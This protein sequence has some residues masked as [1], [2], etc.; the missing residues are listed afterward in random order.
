MVELDGGEGEGGGQILRTALTLS[1][2]TG[3]PFRID[4]IRAN[5]DHPGLRPQHLACVEAL[6]ALTG[7]QAQGAEVGSRTLRFEPSEG[8]EIRPFEYD[9]GTAGSTG[10]LLQ[11]LFPIVAIQGAK[12]GLT[13][14]TTLTLRG[15]TYNLAAPSWPFLDRV[16]R[17]H[18]ARV[19]LNCVLR[20]PRAGYYPRGGGLLEADI[21][22]GRPRPVTLTQRGRPQR[23]LIDA[24]VSRLPESIGRRLIQRVQT[25]LTDHPQL[26]EAEIVDRLLQSPSDG[27]GC[28]VGITVEFEDPT[29][30]D[31]DPAGESPGVAASGQTIPP[32]S[33]SPPLVAGFVGLGRPGKSSEAV[34]DEAFDQLEDHLAAPHAAIDRYSGDQLLLPL[35]LASGCSRFRVSHATGHLLTNVRTLCAFLERTIRVEL[36]HPPSPD[37]PEPPAL[38]VVE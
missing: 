38:V 19:G 21:P 35:A 31:C 34:A 15:G 27:T 14:S 17:V 24:V 7:A 12:L 22:P 23:V 2:L 10:L 4:R 18:Q 6:V 13:H 30:D 3:R 32:P 33:P 1:V 25:R 37:Q 36:D 20:S 8:F 9:I 16:W 29:S 5:R 26:G 28:A 11:T